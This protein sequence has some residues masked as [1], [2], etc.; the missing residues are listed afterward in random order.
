MAKKKHEDMTDEELAHEVEIRFGEPKITKRVADDR[1][2]ETSVGKP[3]IT[4]VVSN[5]PEDGTT[6]TYAAAMRNED[7][8]DLAKQIIAK[9][10]ANISV[11]EPVISRKASA[12]ES[13]QLDSDIANTVP[14][15]R[16]DA[17]GSVF[18]ANTLKDGTK[19]KGVEVKR[20]QFKTDADFDKFV[21]HQAEDGNLWEEDKKAGGTKGSY[22]RGILGSLTSNA[23]PSKGSS[24]VENAKRVFGATGHLAPAEAAPVESKKGKAALKAVRG[25]DT[26]DLTG[27]A[28]EV[29]LGK[30]MEPRE[31]DPELTNLQNQKTDLL[32]ASISEAPPP[33]PSFGQ[34]LTG[35]SDS[36]RRGL[37]GAAGEIAKEVVGGPLRGA[38]TL[39][40][41]LMGPGEQPPPDLSGPALGAAY[42]GNAGAAQVAAP[43]PGN[44]SQSLKVSSRTGKPAKA[45][46]VP[47]FPK[48]DNSLGQEMSANADMIQQAMQH[49]A[50]IE[51]EGFR[52][53]GENRQAQEN[54]IAKQQLTD[55]GRLEHVDSSLQRV[56]H[57]MD[58]T[59]QVISN[60]AKTPDPERYW[61]SH[62]KIMFAIG[63]GMLA[64]AGKDIGGVL[65]NVNQ[66]IDRDVEEQKAEFEAPRNAAK[67]KLAGLQQIYGQYRD[68]KHD[69]Y[70]SS[71]MASATMKMFY[72]NQA[73]KLAANTNS[74]LAASNATVAAGKMRESA[75]KDQQQALQH[76]RTNAVA[77][78]NAK[79]NA[80][81]NRAELAEK[82]RHDFSMEQRKGSGGGG[83]PILASQEKAL[84]ALRAGAE[85][86]RQGAEM[87]DKAT[88]GGGIASTGIN[89]ITKHLPPSL[90]KAGD[91][92]AHIMSIRQDIGKAK[93]G[94]VLRHED[95]KKYEKMIPGSDV[96]GGAVRWRQIQKD[97]ETQ[98]QTQVDTM[99]RAGFNVDSLS[100]TAGD[101]EAGEDAPKSWRPE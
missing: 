54:E 30:G 62:S 98:Y 34:R 10:D 43:P 40:G 16:Q 4:S 89:T 15:E 57:D 14:A 59:L 75:L 52:H 51:K 46:P 32:N 70:E 13:K 37:P 60:P 19:E 72:A 85:K 21:G 67:A 2:F 77:E 76:N 99:R 17:R 65:S 45:E 8:S 83:R 41:T 84:S 93:E 82:T 25:F 87:F 53:A 42:A 44:Q 68:Q 63:V 12:A 49:S 81:N 58:Q 5:D 7:D 9:Q 100:P 101:Q 31:Q 38:A 69:V 26:S 18:L 80:R 39:A 6:P 61:R 66:A 95:E 28:K 71:K 78:Y 29:P 36:I 1:T 48:Q 3:Y 27:A 64:Q 96:Q 11:D 47:D 22:L 91:Y 56:Q 24:E 97:L 20:S 55:Q 23:A 79:E 92:E 74:E 90:S 88:N 33:P 94:G 35:L 50:D 73:E 86:A